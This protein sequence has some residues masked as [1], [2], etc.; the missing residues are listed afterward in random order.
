MANGRKRQRAVRGR[1][2]RSCSRQNILGTRTNYQV[3]REHAGRAIVEYNTL[4]KR[5]GVSLLY[6][7]RQSRA[8]RPT[9]KVAS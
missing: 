5:L 2:A 4:S 1:S 7:G 6:R 9:A 8:R 3:T